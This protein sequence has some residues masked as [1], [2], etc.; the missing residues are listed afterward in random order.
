MNDLIISLIRDSFSSATPILLAALGG[1]FTYHTDVF[2]ISMEGMMLVG[3]FYAVVGSYMFGSWYVGIVFALASGLIISLIYAFFVIY[4]KTDEFITGIG[5]NMLALGGTTYL[6]RNM[7]HVKGAFISPSI[8]SIPKWDIP[9]LNR[10]PV[11]SDILNNHP[12]IVYIGI[13]AA[14]TAHVIIFHTR[15]GLHLRAVGEEPEAARSVGVNPDRMKFIASLLS[16]FLSALAGVYLSLGYVTLFSEN[17][18]N[19][20][21]W[22]SLAIIIL[23]RGRPLSIL[24]MSLIFGFFESVGLSLQNFGIAPQL[25]SMIPYII[26]IAALYLYGMERIK[27]KKKRERKKE[28]TQ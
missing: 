26:T 2:N 15:F 25:T 24:S 23:V 27:K 13:M 11:V 19:G 12:F 20:R 4:M 8:V 28:E 6:L 3:A 1:M 10:I 16:G 18:S 17:M 5:I 7:F 21:G 14:I 22:I 9:G